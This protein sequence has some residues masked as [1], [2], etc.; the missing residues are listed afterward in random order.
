MTKLSARGPSLCRSWF[1]AFP[2]RDF[3]IR[4]Q[5]F[6]TDPNTWA[7]VMSE[8]PVLNERVRCARGAIQ[9]LRDFRDAQ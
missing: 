4:S 7:A 1:L 5:L 9:P 8:L 2:L 6:F 3:Q